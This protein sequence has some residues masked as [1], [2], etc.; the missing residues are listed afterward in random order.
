VAAGV[1]DVWVA[2]VGDFW[3]AGVGELWAGGVGVLE[4][5]DSC[6]AHTV[7]THSATKAT[8]TIFITYFFIMDRWLFSSPV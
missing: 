5:G 3:D 6:C 1:G 2:G 7:A 8:H 4:V